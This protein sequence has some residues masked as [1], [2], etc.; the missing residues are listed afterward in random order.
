MRLY[1]EPVYAKKSSISWLLRTQQPHPFNI[2][3]GER[4]LLA[5]GNALMHKPELIFFDEPFA[6]FDEENTKIIVDEL[7][8]LKQQ[9]I[10]MLLVE[11]KTTFNSFAEKE[12][13]MD[14]GKLIIK[15]NE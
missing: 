4:Q 8:K 3:G 1:K 14:L 5:L 2:S 15:Y 12:L 13:I 7:L 9:Q 10:A 11:H 6:G